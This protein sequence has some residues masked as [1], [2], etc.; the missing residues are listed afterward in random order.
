MDE[1]KL[2]PC[3]F[4]GGKVKIQKIRKNGGMDGAYWNWHIYCENCVL[5]HAEYAADSFYGREYYKTESEAL[6]T[7][8]RYCR[9]VK[10]AN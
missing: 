3:P 6:D 8:E 7:F 10:K 2:K 1:I 4:C 9:E 5:L